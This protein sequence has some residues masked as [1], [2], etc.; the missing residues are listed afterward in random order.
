MKTLVTGA[1]GFIGSYLI[2]DLV[3]RGHEVVAT[4][5]VTEPHWIRSSSSIQYARADLGSDAEVRDLV[6]IVGPDNVVHLA[7]LLAEACE[8][9]PRLGFRVNV[10]ATLSLLEACVASGVTRFVMTSST[11]VFG[12][13]LAEPVADDAAR[14]P[15]TAYGQT[16]LA[17]EHMLDWYRR[18][19]GLSVGAVRF[20]WVYG[21]GRTTGLTAQYSSFLFDAI[22][23]GEEAVVVNADQAGNW[24]YVRDAVKSLILMLEIGARP[25]VAYN[26][27]GVD[28][29]VGDAMNI[30]QELFP[31][32]RIRIRKT[33]RASYP[34]ASSFDDTRAREELGWRPEYPIRRGM[35]EH[36]ETVRR[37][38]EVA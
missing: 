31:D 34:Y 24:L 2:P 15:E 16:K 18:T 10:M 26:I 3:D 4:D 7:G 36:V 19:H 25:R 1:T 8:A 28:H 29:S 30:A 6:S 5:V 32:A 35:K 9:E 21:P 12:R 27:M 37:S 23:R 13:G 38:L 14:L 11:S 17:C 20:P 22:A 33:A